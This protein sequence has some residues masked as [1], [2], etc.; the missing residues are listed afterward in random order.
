MCGIVGFIGSKAPVEEQRHWLD[1]AIESIRHRGPDEH[2]LLTDGP[3]AFGHVRLSIIDL[4]DGQQ[5]MND[6]EGRVTIVYNGEIYNFLEIK[7]ELEQQGVKFLTSSDTEVVIQAYL[8]WGPDCLDRFEG[9]FALALWDRKTQTLFAARDRT[10]KKPFYYTIQDGVFAFASELTALRELP[11]LRFRVER[12]AMARFLAHKYVPTPQ[13]IYTDIHKLK[14]GHFLLYRDNSVRIEP[15][16][17]LPVPAKRG[18][19]TE[20]ECLE[21][22]TYL[23]RQAVRRRLV[24]DVPLG[25]FLSGGVDSSAVVALMAQE[26]TDPVKTFSIGFTEESYDE[27]PF[28]QKVADKWHT[29][30]RVEILSALQTGE[31]LPDIVGMQD[32]PM[33]DPSIVPTYLL[34]RM[35]RNHVTVAL[36]GDGGD[37]LFGGY[38]HFVAFKWIN[39]LRLVKPLTAAGLALGKRV[40]PTSVNYVSP[41]HVATRLHSAVTSPLWM[42]TQKLLEAFSA[43]DQAAL[44]AEPPFTPFTDEHMY[45]ETRAIFQ[46]FPGKTAHDRLYYTYFKQYL[47]DYILVKVDRCSMMHSLEVRSPLLDRDLLDFAFAL[48]HRMKIRG[49]NRKYLFKKAFTKLLPDGIANRQ[50]RGFLIPTAQWLKDLLKP[51]VEELLGEDWLKRQGL[52]DPKAVL[53]MRAEHDSGKADHREEL[54]TLLILQLWLKS[55][56][57]EIV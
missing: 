46:G 20:A 25:A 27:S 54:W 9:M 53:R 36:S 28:A 52:F 26:C 51:L 49:Q 5:P 38:E 17:D 1:K 56:A 29:D 12:S 57:P 6:P 42:S 4:N 3:M 30:H 48:P 21:R 41:R 50:K 33:A 16:W 22:L 14:P 10:G 55:H 35:T 13:T 11:F 34:S 8:T 43:R 24:S 47:L 40:L 15:F 2:G 18:D 7:A 44:W 23:A 19:L 32:E 31:L 39:R 45:E 37:E